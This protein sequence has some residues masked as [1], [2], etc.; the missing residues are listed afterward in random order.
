MDI[1]LYKTYI[2]NNSFRF[3]RF[4]W[5]LCCLQLIC[6]SFIA[7]PFCHHIVLSKT[8]TKKVINP[9]V[10]TPSSHRIV[11][12]LLYSHA[13]TWKRAALYMMAAAMRFNYARHCLVRLVRARRPLSVDMCRKAVAATDTKG[14]LCWVPIQVVI[15]T[16]AVA[17]HLWAVSTI[18][19]APHPLPFEMRILQGLVNPTRRRYYRIL[20][21]WLAWGAKWA[22]C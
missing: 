2:L 11:F 17:R 4:E 9:P 10:F 3:F 12:Q 1:W 16:A 20:F 22:L 15:V 13:C 14:A 5:T 6:C 8:E 18:R 7:L 21:G 19:S